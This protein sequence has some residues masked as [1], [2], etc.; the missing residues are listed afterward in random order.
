MNLA[1]SP[2]GDT[3]WALGH[4]PPAVADRRDGRDPGGAARRQRSQ[5]VGAAP[6]STARR[7]RSPSTRPPA[8]VAL[9]GHRPP[10][11]AR[12]CSSARSRHLRPTSSSTRTGPTSAT[13]ST[14]DVMAVRFTTDGK[15]VWVACDGGV[16]VSTRSGAEGTFV[17]RNAGLAVIEAG[18]VA[19]HPTND[20]VVVLG[21]QDNATQRRVGE[22]L[23]KWEQA[24]RRRRRR[25]RPGR[26]PPLRRAVH[27]TPTGRTGRRLRPKLRST[28]RE[29]DERRTRPREFY[30]TPATIAN[31]AKNQLAVGSRPCLVHG[32][33]GHQVGHAADQHRP[34]TGARST[35][36]RTC[37]SPA[38]GRSGCSVGSTR[39][40]SGCCSAGRSTS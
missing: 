24:R 18:F 23:W 8:R 26:D 27:R 15:Q 4:G 31:G 28:A 29:L 33:L 32:R 22:S 21:A 9:G 19:G 25:V 6:R 38:A 2:S 35:T 40:G 3:V 37:C 16:F 7:S 17:S 14:P 36:A 39:T 13:A 10:A 34:A 30:S 5:S 11:R 12:R 1:A 20:A